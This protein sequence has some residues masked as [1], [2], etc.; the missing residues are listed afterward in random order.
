MKTVRV[1]LNKI[2][3][4]WNA[5]PCNVEHSKKIFLSREYF[6]EVE[7]KKYFVESHILKFADFKKYK[8]KNVLE[9]GCGIGTD[10]IKFIKHGAKYFGVDCSEK[11]LEIAK[12]RVKVFNL[13][14]KN[15][16]FFN[17]NIENLSQIKKLNIKFN[18]I[19]SFGVIHHTLNM[20]N[21]FDEIYK[22]AD[23]NTEIKIMLYAKNSYKNFLTNITPYRYES[24]NGCPV[25]HKVDYYDLKKIIN[26]RFKIIKLEQDFIFPYKIN[27]YK[28]NL[29][30]KLDYFEVMPKKIFNSLKKNIG[31]HMLINLKKI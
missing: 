9:L 24:Q 12:K 29:Y 22:L 2:R 19:Y 13:Q 1:N 17:L 20:R 10:A 5:K 30:K 28:K 26:K 16:H 14:K 21:A 15:P 8:N 25:V 27:P 6:N 11:S 23:I 18:L 31:E 7:K 4:F 3:Q